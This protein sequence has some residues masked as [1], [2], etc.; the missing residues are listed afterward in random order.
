MK[1]HNELAIL[2]LSAHFLTLSCGGGSNGLKGPSHEIPP[3][4]I[5]AAIPGGTFEMG[6][7]VGDLWDGCRPIHKV[8]VSGFGM[9]IY[10][11]TNA[12]YAAYLK[13]AL[14]SGDVEVKNGDVYGKTGK[15]S[16]ELY[17]DIGYD[18]GSDNKCWINFGNGTFEVARG[19]ENWPV[20][21]VSWYGSKSFA[22]YYG[23]DLPTEAEWEYAAR[24]GKQ[25]KYGTDNGEIDITRVNY[26]MYVGRPTP[27]GSY[28]ANPFGLFDMSGNVWEWCQDWY[29][30]YPNE[31]VK[32]PTGAQSGEVRIIRDGTWDNK[33]F[34]CRVAYRGRFNPKDGD[35]GLGFRVVRRR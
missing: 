26:D 9:G 16:G 19:K 35:Y 29:G 3:G 18:Y 6:D 32:N 12:Q 17:I 10:E 2:I 11:V 22:L 24:G 5:F 21:A 31:S 25:Y 28:P 4:I 1:R 7:E 15:L 14:A 27:V 20:V 13:S 8:T 30:S 34:K 33:A 23:F